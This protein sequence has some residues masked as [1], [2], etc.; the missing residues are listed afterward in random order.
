MST[1]AD[2]SP[3]LTQAQRSEISK[4]KLMDANTKCLIELGYTQTSTQ[5]ICDRAGLSKGGLF[6]QYPSRT[7]LMIDTA[8]HI[9]DTLIAQFESRYQAEKELTHDVKKMVELIQSIFKTKA[10]QAVL[11][12]TIAS[13]TDDKLKRGLR[14]IIQNNIQT[15]LGIARKLF[16]KA[17]ANNPKFEAVIHLMI[18]AFQGEVIDNL[19]YHAEGL[20]EARFKLLVE[21]AEK[22]L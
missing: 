4:K 6:R 8:K 14:P 5:T 10:F 16:P 13:R 20:A 18:L 17:A 12:L 2:K 22:E 3:K 9:Y 7:D 19:V 15:V 11:E 21:I 1:K